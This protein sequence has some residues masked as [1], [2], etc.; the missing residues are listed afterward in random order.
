MH[1]GLVL[2]SNLA[3]EVKCCMEKIQPSLSII[4]CPSFCLRRTGLTGE[5]IINFH[6][7]ILYFSVHFMKNAYFAF[8][9]SWL[10]QFVRL[11]VTL[12]NLVT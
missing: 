1:L 3:L 6:V 10:Q 7:L 12:C 4:V 11:C 9:H 5:G 8:L 2:K